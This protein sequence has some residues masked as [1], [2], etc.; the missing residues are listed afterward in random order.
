MSLVQYEYFNDAEL[1]QTVKVEQAAS[2]TVIVAA[3]AD[4]KVR[5]LS[6]SIV[7]TAAGTVRLENTD[8]T[9]LSGPMSLAANGGLAPVGVPVLVTGEGL[10][11]QIVSSAAIAGFV[12]YV[13]R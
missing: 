12:T 6:M 8:G 4:K 10:G 2:T 11:L 9:D 5:V 7:A 3:V 1:A 13:Q